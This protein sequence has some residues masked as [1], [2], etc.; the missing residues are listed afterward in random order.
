MRRFKDMLLRN[1]KILVIDE[2]FKGD[3]ILCSKD[4]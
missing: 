1:K 2:T 3:D 4:L